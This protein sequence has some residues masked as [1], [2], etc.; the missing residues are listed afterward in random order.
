MLPGVSGCS[1]WSSAV[2]G[3]YARKLSA[4]SAFP[5][6]TGLV[7]VVCKS[8]AKAS[9][10]RIPSPDTTPSGLNSAGSSRKFGAP[11]TSQVGPVVSA[12]VKSAAPRSTPWLLE[13][14]EVDLTR[15]DRIREVVQHMAGNNIPAAGEP[16][17]VVRQIEL[18][19]SEGRWPSEGSQV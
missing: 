4:G 3:E 8:I 15:T 16:A 12:L 13:H 18:T 17:K 2:C 11:R 1:R 5:L 19:A 6:V 14:F 7:P 10:V 9:K